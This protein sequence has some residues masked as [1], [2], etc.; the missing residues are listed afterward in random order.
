MT[1]E[2]STGAVGI[3]S[4]PQRQVSMTFAGVLLAMFLSS[5]DQTIVGVAM[6]RIIA[7]LGGF[8]HYTWVTSAYMI[9]STVTVPITGKLIDMYGRKVLYII[10][11]VIFTVFSLLCGLSQTMTQIIIFRGI[12]GVG[13]GIMMANAFTVIGD[14]FPPGERGKYQGLISASFGL[15]AVIGPALGGFL[16][17]I[18][19][20]HWVFLINIPLGLAIIGLFIAFFPHLRPENVKHKVDYAG[21]VL[22]I[23]TVVPLMLAL[24]W[25]GVDFPWASVPI[26]TMLVFSVVMG[27]VFV[28]VEQRSE[29]PILPLSLFRNRIVAISEVAVFF[30]GV[31]M[32]GTII[33]VPLFFQGVLG[34]SASISGGFLTPMMLG[35]VFGSF[36]SGQLLSRTGGHYR[37]Q[38][39]IGIGI[40]AVGMFL[41]SLMTVETSYVMAVVNII[42]AGFGLGATMP[43]YVIAVQNTVPYEMLGVATS[44][45][46]FFRSIGG[47]IGLAVFGSV[48]NN[49][50]AAEFMSSIPA[51]IKALVPIDRLEFLL[52]NPQ[53]LVSPEAQ[54]QLKGMFAILGTQGAAIYEQMLG[55]LRQALSSAL[56]MVFLIAFAVLILAF[57]VNLFI[58]EI[59]LRKGH[60]LAESGD[61]QK[62]SE[63]NISGKTVDKSE[64]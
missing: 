21:V 44:S 39:A 41:L 36:L 61:N 58:T 8:T 5:L 12:Q 27:V 13:G 49:R 50:F 55:T 46:T 54:A 25:G 40:M 47:A 6:P 33:F 32:F 48:L 60:V 38:G 19:S 29:H 56:S 7:D 53:A 2:A 43:L 17:D 4:L 31:A 45:T 42:I 52:H 30:T 59:P 24:S 35:M 10:G 28:I 64:E 14:L 9:A 15:S 11:L 51:T 22:L 57:I 18:L 3:R 20:W 16:T 34:T 37:V 62:I 1:A 23:L 63:G 26:I